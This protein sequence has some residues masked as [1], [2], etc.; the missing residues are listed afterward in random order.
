[1]DFLAI[2]D[3]H[4]YAP[5]I[6]AIDA[7]AGLPIDLRLYPGEEVHPPENPVHM[8]NFGGSFS[9]NDLFSSETYR[10]EVQEIAESLS[11]FLSDNER[12][13]YASCV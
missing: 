1:L 7:Y 4:R 2:T 8:V 6:E 3:H 12:Y 11:N 10:V 9:V 13:A 5:S